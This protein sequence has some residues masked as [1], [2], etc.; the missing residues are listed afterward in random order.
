MNMDI[1][2]KRKWRDRY[3]ETRLDEKYF[4]EKIGDIRFTAGLLVGVI[5][6][7]TA[8]IAVLYIVG[9]AK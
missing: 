4:F 9:G 1:E 2:A 8:M 7:A 5:I 3:R 6:M